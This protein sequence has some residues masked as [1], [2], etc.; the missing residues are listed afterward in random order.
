MSGVDILVFGLAMVV[1]AILS[2]FMVYLIVSIVDLQSGMDPVQM[3]RSVN[4]L[5]Y[6]EYLLH[7]LL[8]LALLVSGNWY[9]IPLTLPVDIFHAFQYKKNEHFLD[10]L[11]VFSVVERLRNIGRVKLGIYVIMFFTFIYWY[12][13]PNGIIICFH[14]F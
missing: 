4:M 7:G 6:P 8:S 1:S 14:M 3:C 10:P 13:L 9:L 2:F 12:A 5:V 11:V